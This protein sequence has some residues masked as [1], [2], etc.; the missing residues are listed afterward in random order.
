MSNIVVVAVLPSLAMQVFSSPL[1]RR[2]LLSQEEKKKKKREREREQQKGKGTGFKRLS[3][4]VSFTSHLGPD[5][6]GA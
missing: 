6:V 2:L 1:L 3:W 4:Y 5:L